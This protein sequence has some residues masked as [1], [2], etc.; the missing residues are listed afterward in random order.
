MQISGATA[1]AVIEVSSN[2]IEISQPMATNSI[3]SAASITTTGSVSADTVTAATSVT[4]PNLVATVC[5]NTPSLLSDNDESQIGDDGDF[6][7]SRPQH[8]AGA[9]T[10]SNHSPFLNVSHQWENFHS[11]ISSISEFLRL[12]VSHKHVLAVVQ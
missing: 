1:P 9:G 10:S 7:L 5:V 8:T 6:T 3:S 2:G 11:V 4:S 12:V